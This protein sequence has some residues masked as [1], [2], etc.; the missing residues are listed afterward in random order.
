MLCFYILPSFASVLKVRAKKLT[1][2]TGN[3]T[4]G[5]IA[6]NQ[7]N[8]LPFFEN[9]TIKLNGI[10]F[11]RNSLNNDISAFYNPITIKNEAFCKFNLT[12][13]SDVKIIT[14]FI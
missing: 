2:T 12:L 6:V 3:K 10:S 11:I 9:L 5:D 13:L 1:Q 4:T 7:T 8:N 14:F